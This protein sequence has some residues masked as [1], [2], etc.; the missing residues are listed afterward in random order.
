MAVLGGCAQHVDPAYLA[1]VKARAK[2]ICECPVSAGPECVQQM[3]ERF[4][5]VPPRGEDVEGYESRLA[6]ADR[7]ELGKAHRDADHC[8]TII[9]EIH[10]QQKQ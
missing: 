9:R 2:A 1:A 6:E 10:R 8:M 3:E 4:P 7:T 5:I